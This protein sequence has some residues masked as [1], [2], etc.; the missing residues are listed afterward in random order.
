MITVKRAVLVA[1]MLF[2]WSMSRGHAESPR[3][4]EII[5][6]R[7]TYDP[8]VITLK[9]GEPVVLVLHSIDVTHGLK[10]A[11]LNINSED[12]KKGKDSEL[13]FT[14]QKPGQYVGQCAHFCGKGHGSMKLQVN[15]VP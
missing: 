1:V 14:P 11:E 12:I 9:S 13:Q 2:L 5:A 10:I 7:F 15:V 6:K 3:R 4:I 8:D